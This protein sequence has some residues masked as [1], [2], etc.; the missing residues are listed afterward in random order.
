MTKITTPAGRALAALDV[1][2]IEF[3][4]NGLV[5]SIEQAAAERN[6]EVSQVVRS[7][8]FR[9]SEGD[10]FMVLVAGKGKISWKALRQHYKRSRLTTA[11]PEEVRA[12]TGYEI[13][14]V[15][16]FGLPA[17]IP[18]IL[19]ESVLAQPSVS[20]GSGVQGTA[21]MIITKNL[22]EALKDYETGK[23]TES[24]M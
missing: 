24:L 23:F 13:G 3:K 21:I 18:L 1:P 16:P 9:C 14:T 11:S 15:N 8:L 7:I 6:Q 17:T 10:Y 22:L 19:D 12:V 2:F 20:L 4:H 5:T